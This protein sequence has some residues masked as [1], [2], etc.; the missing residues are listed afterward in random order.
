MQ[1]LLLTIQYW[2]EKVVYYIRWTHPDH[3]A[4]DGH[5][6]VP[7]LIEVITIIYIVL[8]YIIH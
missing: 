6:L 7:Y 4:I 3:A 5:D 2:A 1:L 8:Y